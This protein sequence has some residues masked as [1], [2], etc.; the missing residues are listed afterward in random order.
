MECGECRWTVRIG[1]GCVRNGELRVRGVKDG[2]VQT[3]GIDC[4][5]GVRGE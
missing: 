4:Q 3:C 2:S 5:Y 1:T